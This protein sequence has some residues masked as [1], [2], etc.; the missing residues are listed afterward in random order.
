MGVPSLT[1]P[2]NA[3]PSF[4]VP[5]RF[6]LRQIRAVRGGPSFAVPRQYRASSLRPSNARA[7]TSAPQKPRLYF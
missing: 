3:S 4:A 5:R 6:V 1:G 7:R 2:R